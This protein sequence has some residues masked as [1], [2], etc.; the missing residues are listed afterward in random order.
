[1]DLQELAERT[2]IPIRRLRH[3]V[4]E[5]LVP[6]LK[7]SVSE[8]EVGRRRKFHSDVGLLI[9]CA[10]RL[11]EAGIDRT[12]V[13]IFLSGL[14]KVRFTEEN[15][16]AFITLYQEQATGIAQLGDKLNMRIQ[17][18]VAGTGLDTGWVHPG[19]PA[20]LAEEY[21][22]ITSICLDIGQIGTQVCGWPSDR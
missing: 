9:C 13:R 3:C 22:P 16:S 4:D 5:D 14:L 11:V 19:N 6:G 18:K 20:R 1:M 15:K 7:V 2:N 21:R 10:A 8:K 12:T 17:L